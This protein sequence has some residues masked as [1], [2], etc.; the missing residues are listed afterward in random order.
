MHE[1]GFPY[2][3]SYTK[4]LRNEIWDLVKN[5]DYV[6]EIPDD[7]ELHIYFYLFLIPVLMRNPSYYQQ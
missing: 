7:F 5:E 6:G 2:L 1:K 3:N 4:S